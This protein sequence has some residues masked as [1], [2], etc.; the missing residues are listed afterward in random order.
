[1]LSTRPSPFPVQKLLLLLVVP[2]NLYPVVSVRVM[3]ERDR[4]K[5]VCDALAFFRELFVASKPEP[6]ADA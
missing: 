6:A 2:P 3:P 4:V 1:M 5:P